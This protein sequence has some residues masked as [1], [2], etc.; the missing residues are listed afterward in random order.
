VKINS[1]SPIGLKLASRLLIELGRP[2]RHD[3]ERTLTAWTSTMESMFKQSAMDYEGFRTFVIWACR[4]HHR[5]GNPWTAQNLRIA[6]DPC[7]SLEKQFENTFI[8]WEAKKKFLEEPDYAEWFKAEEDLRMY[9]WIYKD[10]AAI[11]DLPCTD[12]QTRPYREDDGQ[13][14]CFDCW[15]EAN[16]PDAVPAPIPEHWKN[17]PL[18]PPPGTTAL[19]AGFGE[20]VVCLAATVNDDSNFCSKH[21]GSHCKC[22]QLLDPDGAPCEKCGEMGVYFCS[23]GGG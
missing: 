11:S 8:R 15:H 9:G 20:C 5:Y 10:F 13:M 4:N 1:Q 7:L 3:N 12:C 17:D 16:E 23:G 14:L 2:A 19:G 6:H 22:G 18:E 21:W